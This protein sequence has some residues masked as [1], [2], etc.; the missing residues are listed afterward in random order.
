MLIANIASIAFDSSYSFPDFLRVNNPI[1]FNA[2][3]IFNHCCVFNH[4]CGFVG[5]LMLNSARWNQNTNLL[6]IETPLG[7][8]FSYNTTSDT[9]ADAY[10]AN[11]TTTAALNL[12]SLKAF[13]RAFPEYSDR[14]LWVA[15]E[16]YAGI[17]VPMLA[18]AILRSNEQLP[19]SSHEQAI[20]LRGILVQIQVTLTG[21]DYPGIQIYIALNRVLWRT[22]LDIIAQCE[23][24][25]L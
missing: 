21:S 9:S 3:L 17:Y 23:M 20:M 25:L 24:I 8:G 14:A 5:N 18:L 11:D 10:A 19:E 12:A 16:S 6:F 1:A 13:L 15:G 22:C 2:D 4:C 7:V